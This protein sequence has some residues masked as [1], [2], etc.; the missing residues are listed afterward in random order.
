M[1]CITLNFYLTALIIFL[2][3]DKM[4]PQTD[5]IVNSLPLI[6]KELQSN[7]DNFDN[8]MDEEIS[9]ASRN[10]FHKA[11]EKIKI[12]GKNNLKNPINILPS[13]YK[14]NTFHSDLYSNDESHK[15]TNGM[16]F[17]FIPVVIIVFIAT[18]LSVSAFIVLVINSAST[19]KPITDESY[20]FINTIAK[21]NYLE[22]IRESIRIKKEMRKKKKA[23]KAANTNY[24]KEPE[25]EGM[26][27]KS[28]C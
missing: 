3:F 27:I 16:C 26:V 22:N 21:K 9:I 10:H 25:S 23:Q 7:L 24:K 19:L 2:C 20:K 4:S 13:T 28:K 1:K 8:K 15:N 5:M 11:Y 14:S 18:I 17:I 12:K 6:S